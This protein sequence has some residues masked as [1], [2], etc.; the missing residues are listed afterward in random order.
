MDIKKR[1]DKYAKVSF[2]E[3]GE[4]EIWFNVPNMNKYKLVLESELKEPVT[5]I[6]QAMRITY[7]ATSALYTEGI[8]ML[9][10]FQV[11]VPE[12]SSFLNVCFFDEKMNEITEE[13][14]VDIAFAEAYYFVGE[15]KGSKYV[16]RSKFDIKNN[17][18]STSLIKYYHPD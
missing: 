18:S 15:I 7:L 1:V 16:I 13:N 4:M 10:D 8:K 14:F 12:E 3:F 17:D 6:E 9:N 11:P 5:I 2:T